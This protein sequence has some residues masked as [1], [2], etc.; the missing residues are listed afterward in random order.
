MG[1]DNI[2]AKD[3]KLAQGSAIQG[4]L[5]VF[6]R[7][8]DCCKFPQQW[9][10][11]LVTPVVKKGNS[12]D[13]NNYRPISLLNTPGKL[14]EKIV[15]NSFDDHM[16][17]NGILTDRQWGLRRGYSMES[18]LLHLT[19]SLGSALESY[20]LIFAKLLIVWT[21]LSLLR[22]SRLLVWQVICGNGSMILS[23]TVCKGL[24]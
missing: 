6:K 24:V 10:E 4:L 19:E 1:P 9:Q 17:S 12:L 8:M 15:C 21:T 14:L 18:L 2:F 3:L 16:I 20:S 11:S 23:P 22:N 7:S 13:P 5:E